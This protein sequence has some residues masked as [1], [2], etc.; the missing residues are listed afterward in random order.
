MVER[1]TEMTDRR[2]ADPS[3]IAGNH[4]LGDTVGRKDPDLG[5][6]D[7]GERDPRA[8]RTGVGDRERSA[9]KVVG[10]ELPG[11]GAGGDVADR[12]GEGAQAQA[13]GVVHHRN[14]ESLEVEVDRDPEVYGPV[15]HDGQAVVGGRRVHQRELAEGIDHGAGHERQRGET[16]GPARGI[17][18]SVVGRD[19]L[20]RV[21]NS[22]LRREQPDCGPAPDIVEGDD[23]VAN[24]P[25]C[26]T[27]CGEDIG[28]RD[29]TAGAPAEQRRRIDVELACEIA[30]RGREETAGV[31]RGA[32][33][34]RKGLGLRHHHPG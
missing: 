22:P 5:P 25:G 30:H 4:L 6:I 16:S 8:R 27:G 23:L 34:P 20:E 18:R 10:H 24:S 12:R 13:V 2:D 15:P 9:R 21:R 26:T 11:A 29:A 28:A 33:A 31:A 19:D 14:D 32:P 3:V 17:D 1:A 7:D